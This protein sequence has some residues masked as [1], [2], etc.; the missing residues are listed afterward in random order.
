MIKDVKAEAEILNPLYTLSW[1]KNLKDL[2][3]KFISGQQRIKRRNTEALWEY[4]NFIQFKY[5]GPGLWNQS[6]F[7]D[8]HWTGCLVHV[9]KSRGPLWHCFL[10]LRKELQTLFKECRSED[11]VITSK[12]W[13]ED[14][15]G[16]HQDDKPFFVITNCIKILLPTRLP[17][18]IDDHHNLG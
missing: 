6:L 12:G 3:F 4:A 18:K 9:T 2:M 5:S 16:G 14:K 11:L 13:G 15:P 8:I 7:S 1:L 10:I 17:S